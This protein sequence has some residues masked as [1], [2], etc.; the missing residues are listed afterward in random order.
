MI[1]TT[2]F[3]GRYVQ[4]ENAVKKL[5]NELKRF[6]TKAFIIVDGFVYESLL[7]S[8]VED[9]NSE[10]ENEVL[11]FKGECSDEEI[12][13]LYEKASAGGFDIITGIGGGKTLDT[14]KAVAYRMKKPVAVV[15]TIASTDAPCSALSVIYTESGEFKRYLLLP[16]N[17]DIVLLD[18][19]IIAKAPVRFLISGMGDALATWFEAESCKNSYA[20]NMTGNTG[21]MTAYAIARLCYDTLL[22]YG[23]LALSSVEA[24]V[25]TPALERII[26]ANTLLSGIGF[27]SGGLAASHAIHN[28]FTVLGETH[29]YFH[30]EKVAF[31]TLASLFLTDKDECVIDEVYSFCEAIG[32]P[33]TLEAIGLKNVTDDQ[34]MEVAK[35]S[36][37]EG[38]TIFNEA[39]EITPE[40]V[41]AA[42]KA[43]DS[44]GRKRKNKNS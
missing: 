8:F 42:L 7:S 29:K 38:E 13:R 31:G 40:R 16:K 43:A 5:G 15:P 18:S 24:K 44:E 12:E 28:G 32:L 33:T 23:E 27:E 39:I 21:S 9:I 3:P 4:G 26:E 36:C 20:A 14:A 22:D 11:V 34:L 30:G 10:I 17:P 41:F 2:I 37:S 1:S 6:G 19:K 25:V 35:G